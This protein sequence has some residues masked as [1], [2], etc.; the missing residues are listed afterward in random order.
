MTLETQL[1]DDF[2]IYLIPLGSV[3]TFAQ[4]LILVAIRLISLSLILTLNMK[5]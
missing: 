1:L 4:Q 2:L 3:R 5:S